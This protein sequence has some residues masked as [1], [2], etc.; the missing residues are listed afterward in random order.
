MGVHHSKQQCAFELTTT[1]LSIPRIKSSGSDI[2]EKKEIG[3]D[4]IQ[5]NDYSP[6]DYLQCKEKDHDI[7]NCK[8]VGRIV[9]ILNYYEL[10]RKNHS[11]TAIAIYEHIDSLNGYD[12]PSFLEDWN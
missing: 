9:N 5:N 10:Q 6:S 12:V 3:L 8:A 7:K 2:V 4:S 1:M 11:T